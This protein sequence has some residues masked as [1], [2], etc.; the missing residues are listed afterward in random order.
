VRVVPVQGLAERG[1][2]VLEKRPQTGS[3]HRVGARAVDPVEHRRRQVVARHRRVDGRGRDAGPR[4]NEGDPEPALVQRSLSAPERA[5]RA[6]VRRPIVRCKEQHGVR[7]HALRLERVH[8]AARALVEGLH[9]GRVD[10]PLLVAVRHARPVL[11]EEVR[12]RLVG[13]VHGVVRQVQK[14]RVGRVLPDKALGG[15]AQSIGEVRVAFRAVEPRHAVRRKHAFL[16]LLAGRHALVEAASR[17]Q[18]RP[19]SEVPLADAAGGVPHFTEPCGEGGRR[20]RQRVAAFR[21]AQLCVR[22]VPPRDVVRNVE[23]RGRMARKESGAGGRA[24]GRRGVRV[25][26][27]RALLRQ[28]VEGGRVMEVVAVAA[29]IGPA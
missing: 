23:R 3:F 26:E 6:D 11:S 9:H 14:K 8:D 21:G 27:A 20:R 5:G 4:G 16:V 2:S 15:P 25:G 22:H 10:R 24:I 29:Q 13:P 1:L 12:L 7:P 18:R 28:A 17:G 19:R